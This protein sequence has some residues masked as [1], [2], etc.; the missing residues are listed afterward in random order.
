MYV[1]LLLMKTVNRIVFSTYK[2]INGRNDG[3]GELALCSWRIEAG[4]EDT[5][6]AAFLETISIF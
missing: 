2:D 4:A 6:G 5:F 1:L 3:G